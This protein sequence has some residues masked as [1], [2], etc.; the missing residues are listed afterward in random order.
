[1]RYSDK[2]VENFNS[3]KYNCAQ[4]LAC[5]F[6]DLLKLDELTL[7]ELSK[8]FGGGRC[9]GTC[10]A[11]MSLQLII[12]LL[13]KQNNSS[14]LDLKTQELIEKL[15]DEFKSKNGSIKCR[16]LKGLDSGKL[17]RSCAGCVEDAA[18]ILENYLNG[19]L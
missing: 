12:K 15:T 1:M 16:E 19:Q 17:L 4:S 9:E 2:A 10:G 7:C 11:V 6:K 8:Q 5:T 14:A 18:K 13:N 3:R